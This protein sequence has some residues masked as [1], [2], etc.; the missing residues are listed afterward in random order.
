MKYNNIIII[1]TFSLYFQ[2]DII[3]SMLSLSYIK[4][5]MYMYMCNLIT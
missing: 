3:T 1:I 5:M 4:H 2:L